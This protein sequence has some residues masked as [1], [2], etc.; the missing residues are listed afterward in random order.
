MH[1]QNQDSKQI[2]PDIIQP[3]EEQLNPTENI[4]LHLHALL[5]C[6][7]TELLLQFPKPSPYLHLTTQPAAFFLSLSFIPFLFLHWARILRFS[8]SSSVFFHSRD[9]TIKQQLV[10]HEHWKTK[11]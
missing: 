2:I 3:K 1:N 5:I 11:Q 8:F 6:N 7:P 9:A 10:K 4:Q